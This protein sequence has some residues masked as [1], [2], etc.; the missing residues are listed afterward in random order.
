MKIQIAIASAAPKKFVPAGT[1]VR[2]TKSR[3]TW[4]DLGPRLLK[5]PMLQR[6]HFVDDLPE[7]DDGIIAYAQTHGY[8]LF[9]GYRIRLDGEKDFI[10]NLLMC[11]DDKNRVVEDEKY[12][13]NHTSYYVG[14]KLPDADI[15]SRKYANNFERMDYVL[16]NLG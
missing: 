7:N 11:L 3:P 4:R 10:D 14:V 15:K 2:L 5:I 13:L 16:R 12:R 8:S 9:Y 1:V 6:G